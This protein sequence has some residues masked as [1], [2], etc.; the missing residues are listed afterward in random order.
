MHT[1]PSE[2]EV[3]QVKG[4]KQHFFLADMVTENVPFRPGCEFWKALVVQNIVFDY[5]AN[6]AYKFRCG[7]HSISHH[8]LV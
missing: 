4:Q 1:H 6:E 7:S 5:E 8:H 3:S 2:I